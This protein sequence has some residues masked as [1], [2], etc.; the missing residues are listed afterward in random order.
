MNNFVFPLLMAAPQT[1]GAAG[2]GGFLTSIIPFA[3]IIFIFYFLIIR[4]QNKKRKE[5]EK[6]LSAVKKGDKVVT[7]GGIH[8]TI[9]SVKET[10]VIIKVDDNV[11]LELLRSAISSVV[12][13]G[14]E[15]KIEDKSDDKEKDKEKEKSEGQSSENGA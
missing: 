10:T 6:M 4:P 11:K 8:G 13:S 14:K 2:P 15:E 12:T 1:D 9:Q 5:T 7:I 3:L